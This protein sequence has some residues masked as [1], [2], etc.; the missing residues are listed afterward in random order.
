MG[1]GGSWGGMCRS[2]LY[3]FVEYS[4]LIIWAVMSN[5]TYS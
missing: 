1:W 5:I 3:Y 2:K 4:R